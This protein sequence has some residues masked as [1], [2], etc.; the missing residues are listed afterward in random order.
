MPNSKSRSRSKNKSKSKSKYHRKSHKKSRRS[1]SSTSSSTQLNA[2]KLL[3]HVTDFNILDNNKLSQYLHN[4][5]IDF[6]KFY[7]FVQLIQK[8]NI[9]PIEIKQI[10]L[11]LNK[12]KHDI[13]KNYLKT[14]HGGS[15]NDLGKPLYIINNNKITMDMINNLV[16]LWLIRYVNKNNIK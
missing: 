3:K 16:I 15:V 10:I 14:Q 7:H 11:K 4:L 1:S 8:S 9:K 6:M 5:N 13:L 2:R 12:D